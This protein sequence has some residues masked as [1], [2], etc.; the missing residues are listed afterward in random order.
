MTID[1]PEAAD[2]PG[3]PPSSPPSCSAPTWEQCEAKFR[4]YAAAFWT[5]GADYQRLGR[6]YDRMLAAYDVAQ[7]AAG[8]P[9]PRKLR[10]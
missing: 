9:Q 3:R 8:E 10:T 7:N 2:R 6:E 1:M 5:G 4:E